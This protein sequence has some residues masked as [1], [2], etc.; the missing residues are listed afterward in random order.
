VRAVIKPSRAEGTVRAPASKS[1]AHRL[2]ICAALAEGTSYIDGITPCEDVLAT[3]DCLRALGA[4]ISVTDNVYTVHGCDMKKSAPTTMLYARESGSTLRFIIP[5]A[6]LSGAKCAISAHDALLKRPLSV[7]EDIFREKELMLLKNN[8]IIH[9]DGP[10]PSGEYKLPGNVSSQFISGLLFALPLAEGE[11]V[12]RITPPFGSQSYVRLTLDAMRSFGVDA[13]FEDSHTIRIPGGQ[14][15]GAGRFTVEGDYSGAAFL[16]A[17]AL[18]G[19]DIEVLG[20]NPESA[21]GDKEYQR[22]YPLMKEGGQTV[23]IDDCPDLGPI[24]MALAAALGGAELIGTARLR[25]KES[26]RAAAM[27]E[28]LRK[29]GA[30]VTVY[31][32]SVVIEKSELHTPAEPICGHNDHRVVMAMAVLLT[33]TGGEIEGAEAISK[34]YPSFFE[35]I[36]ALGIEVTTYE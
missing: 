19:S 30:R 9:V 17:L 27:A 12:I 7:Y 28:E 5:I 16:D 18:L 3:V 31:E 10:L 13:Y 11:S 4:E 6:A 20:L 34:S 29:L 15:Y 24:L 25:I 35:D 22:I 33:L 23:N 8:K 1:I 14:R 2:L 36:K 21:Q 26:D 32:N